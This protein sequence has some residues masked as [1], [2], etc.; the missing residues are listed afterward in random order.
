MRWLRHRVVVSAAHPTLPA[1]LCSAVTCSA[2][3]NGLCVRHACAVER[4]RCKAA[5]KVAAF[6][7]KPSR[8]SLRNKR[9]LGGVTYGTLIHF[10]RSLRNQS[11]RQARVRSSGGRC[12]VRVAYGRCWQ[13]A[14][15][16]LSREN[17]YSAG[18]PV[19]SVLSRGGAAERAHRLLRN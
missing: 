16:E 11:S 8:L 1:M 3:T 12:L 14:S 4:G 15:V 17:K 13:S 7:G 5:W 2:G 18:R 9:G 6:F 10:Q 19:N